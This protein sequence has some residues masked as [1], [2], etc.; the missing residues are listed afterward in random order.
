MNNELHT[1]DIIYRDTN[2]ISHEILIQAT[3]YQY[4]RDIL[5][6]MDIYKHQI[7]YIKKQVKY[8]SKGYCSS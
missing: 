7:L 8:K 2:N 4:A 1:F 3:G 5:I 6:H